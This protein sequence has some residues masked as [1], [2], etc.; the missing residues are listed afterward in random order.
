MRTE[1]WRTSS[2]ASDMVMKNLSISGW[3]IVIGPPFLICS[4]KIG[5]TDPDESI[6]FPNLTEA[7]FAEDWLFLWK[8]L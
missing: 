2:T 8:I 3:V 5:I 1:D 4:L 6:T 7:N